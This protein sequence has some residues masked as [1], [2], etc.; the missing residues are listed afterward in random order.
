MQI[1]AQIMVRAA[2]AAAAC[3]PLMA[4]EIVVL[5]TGAEMAAERVERSDGVLRLHTA[6]GVI[7]LR[8]ADVA[9]CVRDDR[10]VAVA[11]A[12]MEAVE[13]K[14]P[15]VQKQPREL[16]D[17]AAEKYGLPSALLHSVAR[18]ESDYSTTAVSHKGA[19]GV[20]QLM[21]GTAAQLNAD[22]TDPAQNIDAG[23]RHLRDLLLQYNGA[24]FKALAAYNAGAG[25]VQKYGGIPPYSETRNYVERVVS[26]Y[27]RLSGEKPAKLD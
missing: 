26:G 12:R 6:T 5:R 14:A 1:L 21:P 13:Q 23:A 27:Y 18:T 15:L 3:V 11:A 9:E 10:P 22:P 24:T 20:M 2:W 16:I 8:E 19:I 25:A 17:E 7:E 4:G